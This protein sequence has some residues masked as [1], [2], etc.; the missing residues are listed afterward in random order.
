MKNG[1]VTLG[2]RF[3]NGHNNVP[4][5]TT[6]RAATN[7]TATGT[8]FDV[9]GRAFET[10]KITNVVMVGFGTTAAATANFRVV[11]GGG[12]L[13]LLTDSKSPL[14]TL[15]TNLRVVMFS[16]RGGGL[17]LVMWYFRILVGMIRFVFWAE[18]VM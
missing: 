18:L 7:D 12:A 2:G 6:A 14:A 1:V 10:V 11:I 16:G 17:R 9:P 13:P 15:A 5:M 8:I 3:V 4:L